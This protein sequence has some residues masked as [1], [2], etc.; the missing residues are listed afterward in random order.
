MNPAVVS[1]LLSDAAR[2]LPGAEARAEAELLLAECLGK[3]RA[4]LY[5]HGDEL[6]PEAAQRRFT[7]LLERRR[8]G[9]PVAQILGRQAFWSL[10]LSVTADTLIPRPDT[11]LLVELALQRIPPNAAVDVLDLGTGSGAIALALARERPLARITAVERDARTLEVAQRNAARLGL[12]RIRLLR[13]DWFSAI[14]GERF[15]LIVGNPPYI[16]ED[17]PHLLQGDLRF[18]PRQA[19]ASGADGLD[20]IRSIAAAAPAHLRTGASLLLEH[21]FEQGQAVRQILQQHGLER[22]QTYQDI[23]SRDRVSGGQ[24]SG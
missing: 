3:D 12:E 14:A 21:G 5:A 6:A 7:E 18:E 24:T 2:Q 13:S 17:D 15:D 9:E 4:W 11:E 10:S 19:L 1:H 22:I 23:E 20:A 8:R 16:A